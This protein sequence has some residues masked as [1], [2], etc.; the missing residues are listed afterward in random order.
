MNEQFSRKT[1]IISSEKKKKKG[2][3]NRVQELVL[4]YCISTEI[5]TENKKTCYGWINN[6]PLQRP[7]HKTQEFLGIVYI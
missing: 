7:F 1:G 4:I 3:G 6:K 5:T 2:G